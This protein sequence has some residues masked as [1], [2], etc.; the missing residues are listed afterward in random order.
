[1]FGFSRTTVDSVED[2]LNTELQSVPE[3]AFD[4]QLRL[5]IIKPH[6]VQTAQALGLNCSS[7]WRGQ[8]LTYTRVGAHHQHG[9]VRAV[10]GQ[11]KDGGLQ[12]LVVT[13]QV[14]EGDHFGGAL[15]D[16]LGC[17]GLAVVH[18]L[19]DTRKQRER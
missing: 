18:H 10:A 4:P 9:E 1:M 6:P 7:G 13:C 11:T 12:V 14:N 16:L 19:N 8:Q 15:T 17:S 5:L 2:H 3:A